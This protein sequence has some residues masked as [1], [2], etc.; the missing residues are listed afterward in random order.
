MS[1][2]ILLVYIYIYTSFIS[3]HLNEHISLFF[4]GK[5]KN[6][7][8]YLLRRFVGVFSKKN[9]MSGYN[10]PSAAADVWPRAGGLSSSGPV[11]LGGGPSGLP[12]FSSPG[13]G[14]LPPPVPQQPRT[15]FPAIRPGLGPANS[16][17]SNNYVPGSNY[18][19]IN[20]MAA[21][22]VCILFK[23]RIL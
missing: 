1:I 13:V 16:L 6:E 3:T 12:N 5:K 23:T 14:N 8:F 17:I 10:A 9:P 4:E 7:S 11:P 22:V 19:S 21:N 15:P 2:Y 18:P 20:P